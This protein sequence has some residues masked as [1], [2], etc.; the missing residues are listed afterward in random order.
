MSGCAAA[1]TWPDV[2]L[3]AVL[4][5]AAVVAFLGFFWLLMRDL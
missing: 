3:A 1:T 4:S 2:A 5:V